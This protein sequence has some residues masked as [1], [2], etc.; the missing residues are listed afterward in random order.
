MM[1]RLSRFV[2]ISVSFVVLL[3]GYANCGQPF[4]EKDMASSGSSA[5]LSV[6]EETLKAAFNTSYRPLLTDSNLCLSC[7][8]DNGVSPFK[9]SSSNLAKS[10]STFK[11]VGANAIDANA[12]S[13]THAPPITG[14]QNETA[15][16][17]ARSKW[18]LA[19]ASYQNCVSS[20]TNGPSNVDLVMDERNIPELYFGDGRTVMASWYLAAEALPVSA[21]L[22]AFFMV[23]I[24]VK[25]E[26]VGGVKTATGYTFS[27]PRIEMLSGEIE[28]EVEAV[29]VQVNGLQPR[30]LEPLLSARAISRGIGPTKLF[31]GS[32]VTRLPAVSSADK[33]QISF[34]FSEVRQRTDNPP[35]PPNP[36]IRA[37][38]AYTRL[39][40]VNITVGNDSTA[41]RWCVTTSSTRPASTGVVC[42]GYENSTSTGWV[43]QRPTTIDLAMLGRA[44]N[45]NESIPLYVWVANNDLKLSANPGVGSV[46]FDT[47]APSSVALT[48]VSLNGTQIAD[49]N[50]LGDSS[51]T[52]SWCVKEAG[53]ADDARNIQNC[54]FTTAKPSYVA[55]TQAGTRYVAVFVRDLAGNPAQASPARSVVNSYG[56]ISFQQLSMSGDARGVFANRCY[57]CHQSGGAGFSKWN[58]TDYADTV[59]K[60]SRILASI[61]STTAPMPQTG[62]LPAKER[63]LIR[64]WFTQTQTPVQ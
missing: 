56:R 64:L 11:D 53:N 9:F 13:A 27:N 60:K 59:A 7:H 54:Q 1:R 18:D 30:D 32:V 10:Y 31:D 22:P 17:E 52:V 43:N 61:E 55:L 29:V 21:R 50:G 26:T 4:S 14:P 40:T 37:N 6:C 39:A 12:I 8:V 49:L 58:A 28:V 42:P 62:L 45:Q 34:G 2:A 36:T 38:S 33:I 23:D 19:Y 24:A 51:E 47:E 3:V 48:S 41:R 16:K 57:S 44:P 35:T 15:F 46:I 5:S 63:A 25:Y 20:P